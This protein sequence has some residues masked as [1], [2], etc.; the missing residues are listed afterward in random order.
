[1]S[2]KKAKGVT[3]NEILDKAWEVIA[4]KGAEVSMQDT[5]KAAD[6][7]RQSVYLHFKTRGGLL[8]A[9]VQR[10]DERFLIREDFYAA[11]GERRPKQR[12]QKCLKVWFE[13]VIKIFPVAIDLTRLRKTDPDAATA[14][15]GRM[16]VLRSWE[17][18]LIQSLHSDGALAKEW[19]VKDATDFLWAVTSV[20]IWELLAYDRS[21]GAG[22]TSKALSEMMVRTLLK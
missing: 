14:W 19:K 4:V 22:K 15:E 20:Q 1:M 2:T 8:L 16:E 6:V 21:W 9:L 11:M 7:S 17:Q 12:L 5:A 10:V 3:R 13:F 18:E